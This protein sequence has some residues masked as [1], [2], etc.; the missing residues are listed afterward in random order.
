MHGFLIF[1]NPR[2]HVLREVV[3]LHV[4]QPIFH[5]FTEAIRYGAA[6]AARQ[7]VETLLGLWARRIEIVMS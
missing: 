4:V 2:Q 5:D 1:T 3:I 6:D 7:K